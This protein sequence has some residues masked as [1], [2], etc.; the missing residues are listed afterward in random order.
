VYKTPTNSRR[1]EVGEYS[2]AIAQVCPPRSNRDFVKRAVN[3]RLTRVLTPNRKSKGSLCKS[4]ARARRGYQKEDRPTFGSVSFWLVIR[5]ASVFHLLRAGA[6][7][8]VVGLSAVLAA[9]AS[10]LSSVCR[11]RCAGAV[12]AGT[13]KVLFGSPRFCVHPVSEGSDQRDKLARSFPASIW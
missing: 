11:T 12:P 10:H 7:G 13:G 2:S 6:L 4:G 3:P 9:Y 1:C 5:P 8:A